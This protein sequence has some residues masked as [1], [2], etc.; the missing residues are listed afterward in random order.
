MRNGTLEKVHWEGNLCLLS[1]SSPTKRFTYKHTDLH[2]YF[3]YIILIR[4]LCDSCCY[5]YF[6]D[7]TGSD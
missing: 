7:E 2:I 4:K 5:S 6:I 3:I 1:T